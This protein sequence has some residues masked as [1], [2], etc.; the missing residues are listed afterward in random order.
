MNALSPRR[1]SA[2]AATGLL[3]AA[4]TACTDS[5]SDGG[6]AAPS[7]KAVTTVGL[8]DHTTGTASREV[9]AVTWYGG[10]RPLITL[11]PIGLADYPEETAIPNLCEP[12]VRVTP[13]YELTPGLATRFEYTD[14]QHYVI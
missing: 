5:G 3:V 14:D 7:G 12:L 13:D 11:D 4:L 2:V 9:D 1:L 6:A 8:A 10:Y